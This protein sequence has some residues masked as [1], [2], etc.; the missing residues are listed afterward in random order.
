MNFEEVNIL[1]LL[2]Q[3][4]PFVMVDKLLYCDREATVTSLTVRD[5]NI[6]CDNGRLTEA[7][8]IENI[9]QTCA[10]R[11][12]YIN[13]YICNDTVKLGFIGAIRNMEIRRLP[14]IGELMTT[15]IIV[16][17]EIFQ[18]TLVRATA[19]AGDE[20]IA[21]AE[22]KISITDVESKKE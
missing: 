19:I 10:A 4:P 18:M 11:M 2:P 1:E 12:G 9:A 15:K 20:N 5:D 13:K 17:E 22:M 3:R 21:S 7:G 14:Q 6:F 8:I 16:V